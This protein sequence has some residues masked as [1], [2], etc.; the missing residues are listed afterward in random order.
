MLTQYYRPED[1]KHN[2]RWGV[3]NGLLY[4][5]AETLLDPTLVV[6]AF[7]SHL[8]QSPLLLGLVVPMRDGAWSLPQLWVSGFLQSK[9]HKLTYYRWFG[10][11]RIVCWLAIALTINLVHDPYLLLVFFLLAYMISSFA[12]GLSGLP[13][14]EVVGKTIPP[15]R[16]GEFFAWRMGMGG[17]GGIGASVLVRWLLDPN[18]PLEFPYNF[19]VLSVAFL[20][21]G[22]VSIFFLNALREPIETE[23]LPAQSLSAQAQRAV[24]VVRGNRSY[25]VFLGMMTT[26]IL[27]SA[28]VPFFAVYVQRNLGGSQAMIGYYLAAQTVANLLATIFFGRLSRRAG[29]SRVMAFAL[30]AGMLMVGLVLALAVMAG[31]GPVSSGLAAAWLVP[32]FILVGI[33]NSGTGISWNSMLL[34]IAPPA[35][36]SLY[37]GFTN[38]LLGVVLLLTGLS[39]VIVKTMGFMALFVFALVA[40]GAALWLGLRVIRGSQEKPALP[41]VR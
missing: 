6:V 36:R 31:I 11:V 32:V 18:G 3:G 25:G 33:R 15:E 13:F 30:G 37:V 17:V 5:A 34:E 39:G 23:T 12:N 38:S 28:A 7:L 8:T 35:E 9:P 4:Y 27:S 1:V 26:M 21:L 10:Y 20:V 41:A 14:M 16:R 29:N 19:G 40:H 22:A 24:A 2:F